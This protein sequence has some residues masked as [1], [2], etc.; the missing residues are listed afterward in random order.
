MDENKIPGEELEGQQTLSGQQDAATAVAEPAEKK[1]TQDAPEA[2]VRQDEPAGEEQ[3]E[4][5]YQTAEMP[6]PASLYTAPEPPVKKKSPAML[7]IGI[8]CVV[9]VAAVALLAAT[10]GGMFMKPRDAVSKAFTSTNAAV[11]AQKDRLA[12]ELPG[13]KYLTGL[14]EPA[15]AK[16]N[17]N[18]AVD[19]VDMGV[20]TAENAIISKIL[21]GFGLKGSYV[22]DPDSKVFELDGAV[23][24]DGADLI[25]LYLYGS[26]ELV[27]GGIPSFSDTVFSFNPATFAQDFQQSPLYA[28]SGM[29]EQTLNMM[30]EEINSQL[31]SMDAM[32][33]A[34]QKQMAE[35]LYR[36][37]GG[38]LDNAT[39][40]KAPKEE[41]LK[42][43][44]IIIPGEDV[45][46][47][48]IDVV[49]YLYFD[50]PF[51]GIYR[52]AFEPML[53][54]TGM[55]YEAF[56]ND[57]I[58]GVLEQEMPPLET[59]AVVKV[60]KKNIIQSVLAV[61]KPV[62]VN[63]VTFE[64]IS[65]NYALAED[66]TEKLTVACKITGA[67]E[68]EVVDIK[69]ALDDQYADGAYDLRVA[70]DVQAENILTLNLSE[71]FRFDREGAANF[72]VNMDISAPTAVGA[73]EIAVDLVAEGSVSET[74][75]KAVFTYPK[76]G[77]SLTTEGQTMSLYFKLDAD[78]APIDSPYVISR[79]TKELFKMS[80]LELQT[81]MQKMEA[82]AQQ[83]FGSLMPF[84]M[85]A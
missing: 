24:M 44:K 52:A 40:E 76:I 72:G 30:Q 75:G 82:G 21:K 16:T 36:L 33:V 58:I 64:G 70:F 11:A 4:M 1:E 39:F 78:S 15:P 13:M 20:S 62:T 7:I 56:M 46:G 2:E 12:Q 80:E 57:Q 8:L 38:A 55:S 17:F 6:D 18:L 59:E 27:A 50:S 65:L 5:P 66:M 22:N 77:G 51:A 81:E 48:V 42:C 47:A 29:D 28:T 68:G 3:Q 60:G 45:K 41:G 25:G 83:F 71:S 10:L 54:D 26:P 23:H 69:M 31:N 63:T 14:A 49:K 67:G 19:Q 73:E 32:S 9:L 53:I 74:D 85:G 84:L 35:D 43:Y 61:V 37:M 34:N 79:E